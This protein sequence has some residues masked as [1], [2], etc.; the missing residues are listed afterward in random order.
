M[1][2]E[3]VGVVTADQVPGY[4]HQC[5]K[6]KVR[7]GQT[8]RV[9]SAVTTSWYRA[10]S[11]LPVRATPFFRL[12]MHL[13]GDNFSSEWFHYT[14]KIRCTDIQNLEYM[15]S[16]TKRIL[17]KEW[18][19]KLTRSC[20]S[21][22]FIFSAMDQN[23]RLNFCTLS[24]LLSPEW[25]NNESNKKVIIIMPLLTCTSDTYLNL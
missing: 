18:A 5:S 4:R 24:L 17:V 12:F 21:W 10:N 1:K 23:Q 20:L 25:Y 11:D 19:Y 13:F 6:N 2:S 3:E 22:E 14:R 7:C 8:I 16:I 15:L 9:S